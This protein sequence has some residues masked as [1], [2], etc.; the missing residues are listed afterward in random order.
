[1]EDLV[2]IDGDQAL[3]WPSFGA[4]IVTPQ[5]GRITGTGPGTLRGR[6][7]CVDGDEDSVTV[8]G[9]LYMT[10]QYCI[11]GTGTLKIDAL[12]S[13]QRA[14]KTRTGGKGVLLRGQRF[15]ARF[16]VRSPALQP[17]P[18]PIP[19]PMAQYQG[20]GW[21]STTNTSFKGT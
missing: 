10:P 7:L 6:S 9:C 8:D 19:D 1:M 16:E 5:P 21:F 4:A 20:Q 14:Q 11:P 3:F 15:R 2:L 12:A 17:G 18:V 13:E